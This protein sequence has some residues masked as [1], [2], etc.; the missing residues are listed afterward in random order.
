MASY[1]T[2]SGDPL[3][4]IISTGNLWNFAIQVKPKDELP[5]K[6]IKITWQLCVTFTLKET[7]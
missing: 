5:R 3:V 4:H 2:G 1:G 7:A 6:P